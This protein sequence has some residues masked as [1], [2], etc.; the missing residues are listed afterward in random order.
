MRLGRKVLTVAVAETFGTPSLSRPL[1]E[2]HWMSPLELVAVSQ[3][4]LV[5]ELTF[6]SL[7][8]VRAAQVRPLAG[9]SAVVTEEQATV[10]VVALVLSDLLLA[11]AAAAVEAAIPGLADRAV[12]KLPQAGR[13]E[14]AAVEAAVVMAPPHHR[15]AAQAGVWDFLVKVLA[16]MALHRGAMGA[17]A[18]P[19]AATAPLA[20]L[21]TGG[22]AVTMAAAAVVEAI[23]GIT[24]AR[25]P[26]AP[27]ASSGAQVAPTRPRIQEMF[28]ALY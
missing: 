14:R 1:R 10:V 19:V 13:T 3:K 23:P 7:A 12:V 27:S 2:R 6:L 20:V 28:D 25:A 18:G 26:R 21:P 4:L 15:A 24:T 16:V 9:I 8:A 11:A 22:T 17:A 5:V